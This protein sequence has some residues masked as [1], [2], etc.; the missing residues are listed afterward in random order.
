MT[1]H[2][3]RHHL[4]Q[5]MHRAHEVPPVTL[6]QA[7]RA[8]GPR[9][10]I[11]GELAARRHEIDRAA[12]D[13]VAALARRRGRLPDP[14]GDRRLRELAADLAACRRAGIA[15]LRQIAGSVA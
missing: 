8:G 5:A 1:S 6:R 7:A 3:P 15:T 12:R 9:R 10:L 2:A 11:A 4:T 14:P 13:T